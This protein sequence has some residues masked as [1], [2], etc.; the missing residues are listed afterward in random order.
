MNRQ[1]T[2]RQT[3]H[4]GAYLIQVFR[5]H[6]VE[7]KSYRKED[8]MQECRNHTEQTSYRKADTTQVRR[9]TGSKT[10][11]RKGSQTSKVL[12]AKHMKYK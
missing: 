1:H 11:F 8:I 6:K 3:S 4:C 7:Q 9:C 10:S 12:V 2:G 5:N